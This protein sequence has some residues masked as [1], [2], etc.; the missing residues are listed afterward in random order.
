M[1]DSLSFRNGS[2]VLKFDKNDH[3]SHSWFNVFKYDGG[4][5][6]YKCRSCNLTLCFWSSG[7]LFISIN[8]TTWP[9][10][11]LRYHNEDSI[12]NAYNNLSTCNEMIIKK[13]I[14]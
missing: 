11:V 12:K 6:K 8:T 13:I 2:Y 4:S 9:Y 7:F 1:S 5:F 14:E 3:K 10:D